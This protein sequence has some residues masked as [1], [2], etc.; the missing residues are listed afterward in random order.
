MPI[1]TARKDYQ[2][3]LPKWERLRD[4]SKGR[5][6]ILKAGKKYVPLLPGADDKE[7]QAYRE[8]GNFYN[9]VSRTVQGMNGAIFQEA[10]DVD[11]PEAMSD[12]LK[13]IT[14]TS[15]TFESFATQVGN[16][17][18]L[19]GRY[20]VLVDMPVQPVNGQDKLTV[21]MRPYC[22][23]YT[24]EN[25]IN[26]RT[27]RQGG[28]EVLTLVVLR[29]TIEVPNAED[30][31][32]ADNVVQYR[33]VILID[34]KAISRL[35]RQT[36]QGTNIYAQYGADVPL[37]RRGEALTFVPFVF[38]GALKPTPD[39]EQPPL[40]DLADVNL[41]H[42]RN[43][44]DHEY[45]LHLVALPTPW[46]AGGKGTTDGVMKIGPSQVWELNI[47]GSA[48]MLEFSGAGLGAIV[49]AME[50]KKK[51]MATLG[52][53]L[54]E[55]A[56]TTAETASAVKL[57]HGGE[58]ASLRTVA[59]SLEQG[60]TQ[61]LQMCVWW[62]GTEAHVIDAPVT[63]ELNKEYLDIRASPQEVQVALTALQAG[64]ISYET[65]YDL[66]QT[67]GWSREGV[68]V[69]QEQKDIAKRKALEPEPAINPELS[70]KEPP[71]PFGA[72]GGL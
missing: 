28:D 7:N 6:N 9:A 44:V 65:W 17:I 3:I 66:L 52:A 63:V 47:Q 36:G 15:V 4:C 54:L 61:A 58:T 64:E 14:L 56:P 53:R 37:M 45:G 42:W 31:Y 50:E 11:V 49:A 71:V 26:W 62:D 21:D 10:P 2:D 43:S 30:P 32:C 18:V 13:D 23:G 24:A 33:A 60:L 72:S 12:L 46:I 67:G 16:E 69:D 39:L 8:R 55:D 70:P 57:R 27:E 5:D 19:M 59:Q 41:G 25:I 40:I 35:Y 34:G 38:L 29:E 51:Q 20:G 48:G 68:D 1:D 22:V